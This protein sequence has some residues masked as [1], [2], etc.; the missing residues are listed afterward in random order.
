MSACPAFTE[1]F[2][3]TRVWT[4]GDFR[5]PRAWVR[6]L[7]PT[8]IAEIDAAIFAVR[9]AG[10]PFHRISRADFRLTQTAKLLQDCAGDLALGRGFTVIGGFPV[11]RYSY[12]ENLFG[13][14][15][16]SAYLGQIVD[17]SYDGA[18]VVDV[19]DKGLTYS[20]ETRGYNTS[21]QLP[22]HTDGACLT[23]LL[24]LGMA[25][26]GGVSVL[27]SA[28]PSTTL[29]RRSRRIC[30]RCFAT[31]ST[32]IAAVSTRRVSCRSRPRRSRSSPIRMPSGTAPTTAT[33]RSGRR[34]RAGC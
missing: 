18:M 33:S 9:H 8:Q 24:C 23:G 1:P 17:Q 4:C 21:A 2:R 15:G 28:A 22:F 26:E 31:D 12:D 32:I 3:D 29:F 16:L 30:V 7:S 6:M 34:R 5:Q 25:A 20:A 14:A 19:K 10:I 27:A 11:E 13:Y